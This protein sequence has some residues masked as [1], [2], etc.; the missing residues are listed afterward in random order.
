MPRVRPLAV[1][2][3]LV[4]VIALSACGVDFGNGEEGNDFFRKAEVTGS[5]FVTE[6]QTATI[7]VQQ[8]YPREVAIHCTTYRG[9]TKI[10][11]FPDAVVPPHPAGGPTVTPFTANYSWD[12]RY[13]EP[14]RY[15]F[16]CYTRLDEDNFIVEPFTLKPLPTPTPIP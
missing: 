8:R 3:L 14:G 2:P 11:D 13:D 9:D 4:L 12:L 16:E 10:S 1:A 6:P 5:M 7:Y 15:T